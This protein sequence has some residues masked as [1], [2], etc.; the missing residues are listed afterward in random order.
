M[1]PVVL[2]V[3]VSNTSSS[4]TGRS[5]RRSGGS[6]RKNSSRSSCNSNTGGWVMSGMGACACL[7]QHCSEPASAKCC[8]WAPCATYHA[9]SGTYCAAPACPVVFG[10]TT[11][12]PNAKYHSPCGILP[13]PTF[14][15]ICNKYEHALAHPT[16]IP[17]GMWY[18][19]SP[20]LHMVG[21]PLDM[22][23]PMLVCPHSV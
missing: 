5:S 23:C 4:S 16:K 8:T 6:S 19:A 22:P 18:L 11:G 12:V 2:Q 17:H 13:W 3:A 20:T 14:R 15:P 10:T 9:P 21:S 1:V 7:Q